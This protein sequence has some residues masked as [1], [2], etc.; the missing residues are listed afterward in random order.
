MEEVNFKSGP[1]GNFPW[2]SSGYVLNAL[3][4]LGVPMNVVKSLIIN[5]KHCLIKDQK[6]YARYAF[7]PGVDEPLFRFNGYDYNHQKFDVQPDGTRIPRFHLQLSNNDSPGL[8]FSEKTFPKEHMKDL[9]KFLTKT[10]VEI[11]L[12]EKADEVRIKSGSFF[13]SGYHDPDIDY[14][15]IEFWNFIGAQGFVDYVNENFRF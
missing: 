2:G 13:Q 12:K 1:F 4:E 8:I 10:L 14:I 5:G 15:F 6:V 11:R 9:H 7:F 3:C